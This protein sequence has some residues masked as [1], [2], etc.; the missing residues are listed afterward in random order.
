MQTSRHPAQLSSILVPSLLNASRCYCG[1][2]ILNNATTGFGGCNM[3]CSGECHC[4]RTLLNGTNR[5]HR[6]LQPD[7]WWVPPPIG[8]HRH[9]VYTG[10]HRAQRRE[11]PRDWLLHG[12]SDREDA[13]RS[14]RHRELQPHRLQLR[15]YLLFQWLQVRGCRVRD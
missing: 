14:P 13:S 12:R 8:I 2:V 9:I 11:L 7:V 1:D 3:P 4:H 6:I 15:W 10:H 5:L